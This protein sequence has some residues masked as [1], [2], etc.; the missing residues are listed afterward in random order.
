MLRE[1]LVVP[2]RRHAL[3]AQVWMLDLSVS[4]EALLTSRLLGVVVVEGWPDVGISHPRS[5]ESAGGA[6]RLTLRVLEACLAFRQYE[7]GVYSM[8][9]F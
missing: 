4:P 1:S 9:R 3:A 5:L 8:K 7:R 6:S 2:Q